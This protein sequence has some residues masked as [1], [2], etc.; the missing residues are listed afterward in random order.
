MAL[1]FTWTEEFFCILVDHCRIF[2]VVKFTK[3]NIFF[4]MLNILL[5]APFYVYFLQ[6]LRNTCF[7]WPFKQSIQMNWLNFRGCRQIIWGS[8]AWSICPA[9]FTLGQICWTWFPYP[10]WWAV[11]TGSALQNRLWL[12]MGCGYK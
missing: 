12:H 4:I 11:K 7:T 8:N 1:I 9:G 3:G 2:I 6:R 5:N 10:L